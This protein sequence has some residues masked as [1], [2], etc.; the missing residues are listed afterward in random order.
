M[1]K[2]KVRDLVI[3]KNS[4]DCNL[5]L[6]VLKDHGDYCDTTAYIDVGH[7]YHRAF[8][9]DE[10]EIVGSLTEEQFHRLELDTFKR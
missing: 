7:A 5:V 1:T 3:A 8:D 10:L 9:H 2:P 6:T 4:G